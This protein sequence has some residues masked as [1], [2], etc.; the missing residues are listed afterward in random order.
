MQ[1]VI[2]SL[3]PEVDSIFIGAM[4]Q[5]QTLDIMHGLQSVIEK[6]LDSHSRSAIAQMDIRRYYDSIPLLRIYRYLVAKGCNPADVCWLLRLHYCPRI[7][8][9][10]SQV[11]ADIGE[12]TIGVLTS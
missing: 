4:P 8:L 2:A 6:G 11:T 3:F 10:F 9:C 12:R 1:P 5:T 7:T